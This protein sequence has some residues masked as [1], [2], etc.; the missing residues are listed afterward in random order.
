MKL[1]FFGTGYVGLVAAACFADKGNTVVCV[2]TN[3]EKIAMIEQGTM[4]IYE[5]GLAELVEHNK[6]RLTFTTEANNAVQESDVI[7][8]AVGTPQKKGS[9]DADLTYL[10][11]AATTI[12]KAMNAPK[13]VVIKSTVPV[14]TAKQLSI[15]P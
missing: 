9:Q 15:K 3:P 4:P 6:E 2:D 10:E 12:A 14:G 11:T 13:I 1:A 5:Q 8:L 7:F